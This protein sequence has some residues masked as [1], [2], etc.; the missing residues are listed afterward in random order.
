MKITNNLLIF[1]VSGDIWHTDLDYILPHRDQLIILNFIASVPINVTL[2]LFP[3]SSL[4]PIPTHPPTPSAPLQNLETFNLGSISP[5]YLN[6]AI[7][8]SIYAIRYPAVFWK[9]NKCFGT[10]FSI[11]LFIAGVHS[12]VV[13]CGISVLYKIQVCYGNENNPK[14]G[15]LLDAKITLA[16]YALSGILVL[17]TSLV[18][19]LHGYCKFSSFINRERSKRG[20]ITA[21][22]E[23]AWGYFPHCAALCVLI[24]SAVVYAPLLHDSALIYRGT[25]DTSLLA[26][27]IAAIGHLFLW[28]VT[29]LMLTVKRHWTFKLR[30][31]IG[32]AALRSARS[33]KLVTD[34]DLKQN[35]EANAPL[36]VVGNGRTYTVAESSPKKAIMAV[37]QRTTLS[38]RKVRVSEEQIYWLRP[39]RTPTPKNSPDSDKL[40]WIGKKNNGK[41]KVTFEDPCNS[42]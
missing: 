26:C 29:W 7:A 30:V 15:L 22:R 28:V 42:K 36:L 17:C 10:L 34:V 35:G 3:G 11:Q 8:L 39:N 2:P 32:R 16:L 31:T 5:E 20:E 6:Y 41:H 9:T 19:Y 21:S 13:Y 12:L 40:N 23:V 25:L 37:I 1:F 4:P 33:I 27:V 24:A 38:E 18:L 14:Q